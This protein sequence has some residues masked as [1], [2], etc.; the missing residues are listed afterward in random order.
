L[1]GRAPRLRVP[2]QRPDKGNMLWNSQVMW[3]NL[4]R[5]RDTKAL[6]AATR[7]Q[8][9]DNLMMECSLLRREPSMSSDPE[10]H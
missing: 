7:R 1:R 3:R 4:M 5:Q 10:A 6:D 8:H 2:L 9:K